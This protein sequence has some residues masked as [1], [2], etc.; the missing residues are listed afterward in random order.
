MPLHETLYDLCDV[1][2]QHVCAPT[3]TEHVQAFFRS[4]L[5]A[6]LETHSLLL[7][8]ARAAAAAAN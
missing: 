7:A 1:S 5:C 6:C 4:L 2:T 3:T 8:C